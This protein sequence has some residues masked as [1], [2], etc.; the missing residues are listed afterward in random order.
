MHLKKLIENVIKHI[1]MDRK[2]QTSSITV[3][4]EY[5]SFIRSLKSHNKIYNEMNI[6]TLKKQSVNYHRIETWKK[7]Q[8]KN[9]N[10]IRT[11]FLD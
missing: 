7:K 8:I 10:Q 11:M 5:Y 9:V 3:L 6:P 2:P 4:I 1:S